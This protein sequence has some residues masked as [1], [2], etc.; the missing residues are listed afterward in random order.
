ME[1]FYITYI[2]G[3]E[4]GNFNG[5]TFSILPLPV[6]LENP[7]WTG[8]TG[9]SRLPIL[10]PGRI[11][12]YYPYLCFRGR[13]IQWEHIQYFT[14]TG[15]PK[16]P[17]WTGNTGTLRLPIFFS[18]GILGYYLYLCFR[19]RGIQWWQFQNST[20]TGWPK[21]SSLRNMGNLEVP[22]FPVRNGFSR[23]RDSD[24]NVKVCPLNSSTSK[25]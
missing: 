20:T 22:V 10:L 9:T 13:G 18:D 7:G 8:N 5:D 15:W 3:F 24:M 17:V 12:W 11:F 4:V 25:T 16:N 1:F 23:S 19:G 6:D 14:T 2:Y 21:K